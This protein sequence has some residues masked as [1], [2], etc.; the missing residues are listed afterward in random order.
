MT[1][2]SVSYY[3][4]FYDS[5]NSWGYQ[6]EVEKKII[7]EH[8]LPNL[9]I[10]KGDRILDLGCGDGFHSKIFFDIGFDIYGIDN[11]IKA[12]N[13]AQKRSNAISF[14][15]GDAASLDHWFEKKYFDCIYC[16]GLS[17]YHYELND[18]NQFG[19]NVIF[20]TKKILE[21]LK[22]NGTF[23]LQIATDFSGTRD[24]ISGIINNTLESYLSFFKN[25]GEIQCVLDWKGNPIGLNQP[26]NV[27]PFGIIL[28][29]KRTI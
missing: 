5:D 22:V 28:F 21:Y 4:K 6:Y 13:Q 26:A 8:L 12:I 3:D 18:N 2:H 20:E 10:R 24:P 15:N 16:R 27:T 29:L 14:I 1:N 7:C 9:Q 19:I 23:I 11:S 25:F 17:W